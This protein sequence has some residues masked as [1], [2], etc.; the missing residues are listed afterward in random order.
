MNTMEDKSKEELIKEIKLLRKRIAELDVGGAE[1]KQMEQALK[2]SEGT[3]KS[4]IAAAPIGIGVVSEGVVKW[5][6]ERL[7]VITGYSEKEMVG[8]SVRMLYAEDE[9]FNRV[10]KSLYGELRKQGI[11]AIET[12]WKHKDGRILNIYIR[13]SAIEEN[14]FG[15]GIVFTVTDISERKKLENSLIDALYDWQATFDASRDAVFV[16]DKDMRIIKANRA[17]TEF[18]QKPLSEITGHFCYKLVHGSDKPVTDCPQVKAIATKKRSEEDFYFRDKDLWATVVIDPVFNEKGEY[19]GSIHTIRDITE[20]KKAEELLRS[21]EDR[22]KILFEFAPVAYYISDLKGVLIDGNLKAEDLI[23]YNREELRGKNFLSLGALSAAQ[24]PKAVS[25][26]AKNAMGD[27]TGPDEFTLYRKDGTATIVE[28]VTHPIVI[29][30]KTVVLGMAR[31]IT[32]RKKSEEALKNSQKRL[33]QS[34]KMAAI[35]NFSAGIAHEVKNPLGVILSGAEFLEAKLPRDDAEVI[36][37]LDKMKKATLRASF[38]LQ[39]LLRFAR[40]S[41]FSVQMVYPEDFVKPIVDLMSHRARL[42]GIT[43]VSDIG[44]ESA[45]VSADLN[46]I[47]QVVFNAVKNSIEAMVEGGTITIRTYR[48]LDKKYFC[49][50]GACVIEIT[51]TGHGISKENLEKLFKP[52]FTTKGEGKGTGLG[53][54]VSR[55]ILDSHEGKLLIDSVEGQGTRVRIVLP[56]G[57]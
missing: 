8:K 55:S 40:P 38:V 37:T 6:N 10:E 26:L 13:A 1:R 36:S 5:V 14:K 43:I 25:L 56:A 57:K 15:S 17:V 4:V 34:E 3:L 24:A 12:F 28:I 32:E 53:L 20:R 49:G 18:L 42:A 23:G 33:I 16:L 31:D 48:S 30:D 45:A 27:A 21:S 47:Q 11:A 54:Y 7:P 52:F 44:P 9:E 39:S 35:G 19:T 29:H 22:F 51:D 41:K 46:Q 50:K 2:D